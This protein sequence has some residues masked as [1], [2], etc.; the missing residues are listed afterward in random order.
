MSDVR[1]DLRIGFQVLGLDFHCGFTPFCVFGIG[2]VP[3]SKSLVHSLCVVPRS[4]M[5]TFVW[6]FR[7]CLK[8]RLVC[9]VENL[10]RILVSTMEN[11]LL[12]RSIIQMINAL[13]LRV[14]TSQAT[15]EKALME[16]INFTRAQ[17]SGVVSENSAKLRFAYCLITSYN[18]QLCP[19][20][21]GSSDF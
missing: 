6:I 4:S 18:Q 2:S 21:L 8:D 1:F 14:M 15:W 17:N 10:A 5:G 16:S 13:V 11:F 20:Y 7:H 3:G 9:I 19:G 12:W